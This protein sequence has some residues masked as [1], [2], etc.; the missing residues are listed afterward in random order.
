M[1]VRK[2]EI[3][4]GICLKILHRERKIAG[5]KIKRRSKKSWWAGH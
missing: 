2:L 3:G 4:F 1:K 5:E